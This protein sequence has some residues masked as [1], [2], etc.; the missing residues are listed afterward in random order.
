MQLLFAD[1]PL[2]THWCHQTSVITNSKKVSHHKNAPVEQNAGYNADFS[3]RASIGTKRPAERSELAK[4]LQGDYGDP[5][6]TKLKDKI[7][8]KP[9]KRQTVMKDKGSGNGLVLD[10]IVFKTYILIPPP[11]PGSLPQPSSGS[12]S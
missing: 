6:I 5:I 3:T 2:P 1:L 11:P 7:V 12:G 4:L 10:P 9:M 8:Q